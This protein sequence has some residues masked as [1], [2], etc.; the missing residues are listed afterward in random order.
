MKHPTILLSLVACL[1]VAL[2]WPIVAVAQSSEPPQPMTHVVQRGETVF[3]IARRYGTTVDA[4]T[5]ANSISDPRH[6]YAGQQLLIPSNLGP[7][8]GWSAHIVQ[9][10]ETFS[11]IA[12][13]HGI[14]WQ[15][16]ALSNQLVNPHLLYIGQAL[17][18]PDPQD[19]TGALYAL[20]Q[21]ETLMSVAF[22]HG[23]GFWE[24]V[25]ANA[26][27]PATALMPDQWVLV[28]GERPAW[29]PHPF[30][31][32][33]ISPA[34]ALQGQTVVVTVQ[35]DEPVTMSGTLFDQQ[36]SF[37][38]E[39]GAYHAV[40][41]VHT[42]TEPGVYELDISATD[43]E[44]ATVSLS[45]GVTVLAD[46]YG[47]ERIDVPDSRSNLL[48]PALVA[49]ENEK[50]ATVR[51][52]VTP[53]RYWHGP[54]QFPVEAAINSYFGTRRS[55]N[56]SP[57]TSYHS[58]TDFRIGSG[59]AVRAPASGTVV[60][61]E[62]LVVRGNV[63]V[64]DHGWGV[65]TG[66]WHLSAIDVEVGQEVQVGEVIGRVGNTGLSTGAHLHWE[67]WAGGVSVDGIQWLAT[68]YPWADLDSRVTA[69]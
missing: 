55:Y 17:Q 19:V 20:Q 15:R 30:T 40:F 12:A 2:T 59:A 1:F 62:P 64:L 32:I 14:D 47:Y 60:M 23:T 8:D 10:G 18:L 4:I 9:A 50:I 34:P 49:E 36:L 37:F 24:L 68:A 44:G 25:E 6:V 3:S 21:G 45:T 52:I 54:F 31:E 46:V 56:G 63:I 41:G 13:Q 69:Q 35:T 5:H 48:D 65:L 7:V 53:D 39:E 51:T 29:M 27:T 57:Y 66:Y 43:G 61:A 58:G 28:P 38:E 16:L 26:A 33:E 67:V 11:V 22:Q 42:F